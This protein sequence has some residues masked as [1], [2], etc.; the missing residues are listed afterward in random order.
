MFEIA[1]KLSAIVVAA[2]AVWAVLLFIDLFLVSVDPLRQA[3]MAVAIFTA[4]CCA[5]ALFVSTY[6]ND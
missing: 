6:L 3:A 1:R 4:C 5:M 2:Y